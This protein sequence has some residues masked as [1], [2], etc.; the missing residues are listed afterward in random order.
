METVL[1]FRSKILVAKHC[2][3]L[4]VIGWL[5]FIRSSGHMLRDNL[6]GGDDQTATGLKSP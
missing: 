1:T 2:Y 4:K 6:L 3:L 5:R